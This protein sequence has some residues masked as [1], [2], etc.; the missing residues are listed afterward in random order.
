MLWRFRRFFRHF[1]V[2]PDSCS[3][4]PS[5]RETINPYVKWSLLYVQR[6]IYALHNYFPANVLSH[7]V[8]FLYGNGIQ[9]T[10]SRMFRLETT[11]E[12]FAA[13]VD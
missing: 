3:F 5:G 4:T 7:A 9:T 11:L 10:K 13:Y 12:F 8:I 2:S 6:C 1:S